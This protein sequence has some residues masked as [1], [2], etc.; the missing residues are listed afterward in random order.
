VDT[1]SDSNSQPLNVSL[2]R[3]QPLTAAI[4]EITKGNAN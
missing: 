2:L 3:R 1:L 4:R